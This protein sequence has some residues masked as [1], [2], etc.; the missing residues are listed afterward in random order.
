LNITKHSGANF[1]KLSLRATDS[2]IRLSVSD[3]GAGFNDQATVRKLASFGLAGM[4]ER[5]ALFGGT[6]AVRSLVGKGV[7]VR[8]ELPL[9]EALGKS[10][11]K[12]TRIV[13]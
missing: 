5:A 7:T 1:V 8:L 2:C 6:L 12:N 13:D 9:D 4:R 10:N 11:G 3:D